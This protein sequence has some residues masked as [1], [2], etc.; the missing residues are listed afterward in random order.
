MSIYR[1]RSVGVLFKQI[2]HED[3]GYFFIQDVNW[4]ISKT[5]KDNTKKN[6]KQTAANLM[7]KLQQSLQLN[8]LR[9]FKDKEHIWQD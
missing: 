7:N 8:M 5:T 1:D 6:K 9:F 2:V 3:I 4:L